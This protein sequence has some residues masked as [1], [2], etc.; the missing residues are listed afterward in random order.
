MAARPDTYGRLSTIARRERTT[1]Q[2][3]QQLERVQAGRCAHA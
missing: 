1:P 2:H 3:V